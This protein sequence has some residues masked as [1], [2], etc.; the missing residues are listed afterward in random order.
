MDDERARTTATGGVLV[1]SLVLAGVA[2]A[3]AT[4]GSAPREQ[5]AVAL[6]GDGDAAVTLRL[7]FDRS[8]ESERQAFD[9]L[10]ANETAREELASAFASRLRR[11]AAVTE[12]E[13]GRA[14]T[15]ESPAAA[16]RTTDDTGVVELTVTWRGLAAVEGERIVLSEP[17]ASGFRTDRAFVVTA[18]DG[19]TFT[20][21]EPAADGRL[22]GSL[23]WQAD[24]SLDGLRVVAAPDDGGATGGSGTAGTDGSGPGLT[25]AG[26]L[27][28]LG[29]VVLLARRR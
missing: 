4:G 18:P 14:M 8:T 1:A 11:V 15:V 24:T 25:A 2:T 9:R 12:N 27:A 26:A 20:T 22:D 16:I 10:A 29:G 23:R 7:T 28:A 5:F 13:T 21:V 17:F 3:S 6:E 19:Y